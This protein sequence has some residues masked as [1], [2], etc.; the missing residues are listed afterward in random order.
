MT[1]RVDPDPIIYTNIG[2]MAE[3][4]T[5]QYSGTLTEED[6]ETAIPG[7]VL[8]SL[9]ITLRDV[10]TNKIINSKNGA[11]ALNANNVAVDM[12]T[13]RVIWTIMPGDVP[14]LR[15]NPPPA[16]GEIETHEAVFEWK[17]EGSQKIGRKK[18][19][20]LVEKYLGP[21]GAGT[22]ENEFSSTVLAP[23][24]TEPIADATVWATTDAAGETIVAGPVKTDS[25]GT[26]VLMLDDGSY[27]LWVS[28]ESY[29]FA[30]TPIAV[31]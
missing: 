22:G 16:D 9:T 7:S 24:S 29:T 10:R 5:G 4:G 3:G 25:T 8:N 14:F 6:G 12:D 31:P 21:V 13:G 17:W 27:Y 19:F 2:P 1:A 28:H 23:D 15:V 30:S 26:F 18:I 20:I 11:N